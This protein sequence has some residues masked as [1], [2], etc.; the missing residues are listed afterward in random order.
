MLRVEE[1]PR[2]IENK[3]FVDKAV[4]HFAALREAAGTEVDLAIDFHGAVKSS[5]SE[6]PHQGIGT[7]PT[8]VC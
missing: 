8:D 6:T 2:I 1:L 7:V 4:D 3:A 5:N